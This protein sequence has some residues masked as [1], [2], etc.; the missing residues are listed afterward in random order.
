[1]R[2]MNTETAPDDEPG[3]GMWRLAALSNFTG[4]SAHLFEQGC[5]NGSIPVH[6]EYIGPQRIR[7]IRRLELEAW[8]GR[9]F[10]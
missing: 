10:D 8:L 1:M 7:Y 5:L 2:S 6:I 3:P 9:T 4:M